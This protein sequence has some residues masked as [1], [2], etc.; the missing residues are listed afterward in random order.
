[1]VGSHFLGWVS[2]CLQESSL[3]MLVSPEDCNICVPIAGNVLWLSICIINKAIH[4]GSSVSR[5]LQWC[6][7]L[8]P[9]YNVFCKSFYAFMPT[10]INSPRNLYMH[11]HTHTYCI[12]MY[13]MYVWLCVCMYYSILY[14]SM[15]EMLCANICIKQHK[16][17]ITNRNRV[18]KI[19]FRFG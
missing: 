6:S 11:M 15:Y 5:D 14:V 12:C 4:E 19:L 10:N 2:H 17:Q 18:Y 16:K 13:C 7:L 9:F 1:M 3:C 8:A